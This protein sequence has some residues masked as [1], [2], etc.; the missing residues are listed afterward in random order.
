MLGRFVLAVLAVLS[1]VPLAAAD[2]I[3]RAQARAAFEEA[4]ALAAADGGALW[5][6]SLDG[7]MAFFDPA[8]RE[9][10]ANQAD[11]E[12]R[13]VAKDG[14][15]VGTLPEEVA[16]ANTAIDWAGV[17]WTMILWPLPESRY[18]RG[19]LLLHESFHRIQDELHLPAASPANAHLDSLEAR[20]DLALEFRALSEALLHADQARA[21]AIADAAAFRRHRQSLAPT[22]AA[23]ERALERNEGLAEYTG[24]R[25][26]GLPAS[27]L[28]SRVAA[29]LEEADRDGSFSRSFAYLT[30]PAY[31]LLLD[32]LKPGWRE[33]LGSESDL[34]E[35]LYASA[36][37]ATPGDA[38][39][40][41]RLSRYGGGQ[42]IAEEEARERGRLERL[43]NYRASF[44]D[45]P[46]VALALGPDVQF[47]F[48]P[49]GVEHLDE[50]RAV[51]S[52][53]RVTAE[54]GVLVVS[55]IGMMTRENGRFVRVTVPAPQHAGEAPLAGEGWTLTLSPGWQLVPG[56]RA[57]D[58]F[59]A[60]D[61][62][63]APAAASGRT[64]EHAME[65]VDDSLRG[66]VDTALAKAGENAAQL[67][68]AIIEIEP[69]MR[70]GMAFLVASMPDRD[71]TT[72][73]ADDL[74]ENVRLAYAAWRGAPWGSDIPEAMF[75]Q[76]ILPY[77]NVNE[78][79]D[80]WRADF[81]R[82]FQAKAW[83]CGDRMAAVRYLND[84]LNDELNVHYH[85]SK[86]KKPDQSPR[87]SIEIGYAS[88][89]GLSILLVDACRA[90]GIPAR[91]VG[92]PAWKVVQG[93]HTWVE[94]FGEDG[95]GGERWFNVGDTGS[96]PRGENWVNERCRAETDPGDWVHAVWASVWR[97]TGKHFPLCWEWEIDYVAGLNITRFYTDSATIEVPLDRPGPA[98][99]DALWNGELVARAEVGAGATNVSL[100]LARNERFEVVV[101]YPDG[102]RAFRTIDPGG[103]PGS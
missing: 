96:D 69:E 37:V 101:R 85:A 103:E 9:I 86:R 23:E 13:L 34:A 21:T 81:V 19:R 45:G 41:A 30:G 61:A 98:M 49:Y 31:G 47:S 80:P 82:R 50:A 35:L 42:L 102:T 59:A 65:L 78:G 16:A 38:R 100:H 24:W 46:V 14:V 8:T 68:R 99:A 72:L 51:Y 36:G 89:T 73:S 67:K 95:K 1:L 52:P 28:P 66:P 40:A 3:D 12:G 87:E 77:A 92:C 32:D 75:F 15:F 57:G 91:C 5:H 93:N 29:R 54:W 43:A 79:R 2:G 64:Y 55:G 83:A 17:R 26:C 10:A 53:L 84:H 90:A 27:A 56:A 39:D 70:P 97:P 6:R 20:I 18:V 4:K 25:L 63:G 71:L 7:P 22:A 62:A 58:W 11:P 76:Y 60:S 94:V 48:N 74:L 33:S 44:V 88:C